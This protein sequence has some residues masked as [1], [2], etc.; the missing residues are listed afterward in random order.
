MSLSDNQLPV[1]DMTELLIATDPDGL[2]QADRTISTAID[3]L[4]ALFDDLQ[5]GLSPPTAPDLAVAENIIDAV[6][7]TFLLAHDVEEIVDC[8]AAANTND[9]DV[10]RAAGRMRVQRGRL[11]DLEIRFN[12]WAGSLDLDGLSRCSPLIAAH[13]YP[14][15][16]RQRLARYQMSP[17]AEALAAALASVSGQAWASLRDDLEASVTG[18]VEI[19]GVMQ[20]FSAGE[21]HTLLASPD[22]DLRR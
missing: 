14:L 21:F 9:A 10:H 17:D 2:V 15:R 1:W 11:D 7:A 4:T 20:K 19:D 5:V 8:L 3:E 18:Y 16:Q 12:R 22:R 6:N 13:A